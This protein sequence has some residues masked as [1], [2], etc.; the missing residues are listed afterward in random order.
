VAQL[1]L[2]G[3]ADL[4]TDAERRLIRKAASGALRHTK[5]GFSSMTEDFARPVGMASQLVTAYTLFDAVPQLAPGAAD[6]PAAVGPFLAAAGQTIGKALGANDFKADRLNRAARKAA[7]LDLSKRQYNKRFRLLTRMEAKRDRLARELRKRF[8]TLVSKSRLASQVPWEEFAT[9]PVSACFTAYYTARCN[10][11][12]EFTISGQQRPY[13]EIADALFAVCK[14]TLSANWWT[15]AHAFPDR[16]VL[17]RLDDGRKGRLLARWFGVLEDVAGFLREVWE[18]NR[19]DRATM[20]VR[21]GNDSS[22]WNATAGAWNKA[23][24]SWIALLHALD[25][26]ELLDAVCPGKVLRLMAADVAYWHRSAG[27]GLD[28]DTSVWAELPFPWDVLAG[29]AECPRSLVEEVCGRH[30]VDPVEKGWTAPRPGRA[31]AAF[32]PTPELVHGV[33]VGHPGLAYI[34]RKAGFFSGKGVRM[35]TD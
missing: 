20:I 7:G 3:F 10:L 15:V 31:V 16:E 29:R 24:E 12:S 9:D 11:R 4:Y 25:A 5:G 13:D 8:F 35:P 33:T 30:G 19:F 21:R 27:G 6:D 18:A 14:R 28:P 22:T 34:L 17:A 23:R 32:R 2:D 26:D 1:V